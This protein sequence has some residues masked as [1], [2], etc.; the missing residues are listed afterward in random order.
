MKKLVVIGLVV[1]L[2]ALFSQST[3]IAQDPCKA[4]MNCDG[5]VT[6]ADLAIFKGEYGR[7]DCELHAACEADEYSPCFFCMND[8]DC[9][10]Y[11][12]QGRCCCYYECPPNYFAICMHEWICL[13]NGGTCSG[14]P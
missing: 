7:F 3:L 5:K 4:D 11:S 9:E 14:S 13:M 10:Y 8:E 2:V 1:V 12:C 6:G